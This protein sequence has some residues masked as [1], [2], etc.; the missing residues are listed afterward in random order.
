MHR[1]K[2]G[3]LLTLPHT[4]AMHTATAGN[5]ITL[6]DLLRAPHECRRIGLLLLLLAL[7]AAWIDMLSYLSLGRV[8]ASFMTGNILFIGLGVA[9]GN[10]GLVIHALVA[11][12]AFIVGVAF[13]SFCLGCATQRQTGPAWH[14]TFVRYLLLE[15][16][17]LL[18]YAIIWRVTSNL[19]QQAGVQFLLLC[20][21]ALA[22][23]MQGAL[24][25][26]FKIP[27]VVADALTATLITLGQRLAQGLGH[28]GPE[29]QE[30]RW[31]S[32]F[33]ALLCLIYVVSAF[34]V[35]LTSAFILTPVVPVI[36]VTIAIFVLLF[37]SQ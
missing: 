17:L 10:S 36:V 37:P 4:E 26:S 11:V 32:M 1:W 22:M 8:F 6:Q 3:K 34:V 30:W 20:L 2:P 16:L 12:L 15:W 31:S 33:L 35:A 18:V 5:G 25:L 19:S 27:G 14:N 13:G 29:S 7:N 28:P 24:V 9:Q 21:A 23:G